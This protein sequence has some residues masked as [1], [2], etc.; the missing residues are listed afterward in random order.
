MD[1]DLMV[2]VPRDHSGRAATLNETLAGTAIRVVI[3]RRLGERRSAHRPAGAER[4]HTDRRARTRVVAYVYACPIVEIGMLPAAGPPTD[5][6]ATVEG[7]SSGLGG[8]EA[9]GMEQPPFASPS[10]G[11]D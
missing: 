7:R 11:P 4:R 6:P 8:G 10:R 3:D 2:I 9:S 5:F 1:R